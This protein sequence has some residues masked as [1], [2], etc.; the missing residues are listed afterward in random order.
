MPE[1]E[2]PILVL[3]LHDKEGNALSFVSVVLKNSIKNKHKSCQCYSTGSGTKFV[4][5]SSKLKAWQYDFGD[6]INSNLAAV[7]AFQRPDEAMSNKSDKHSASLKRR[8]G[9]K[10]K[11]L[12]RL[13][14]TFL[15]RSERDKF[16]RAINQVIEV[17]VG[18][19][20]EYCNQH[21]QIASKH[22]VVR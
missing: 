6:V 12:I 9:E 2:P 3:F 16:E 18:Q 20:A 1:P 22:V 4:I 7:G 13:E 5:E 14:L 21:F 8:P 19:M 11:N 17:Y 10:I 15:D